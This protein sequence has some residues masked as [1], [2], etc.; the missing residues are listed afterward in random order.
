MA[1]NNVLLKNVFVKDFDEFMEMLILDKPIKKGNNITKRGEGK[2]ENKEKNREIASIRAASVIRALIIMNKLCYFWTLTYE[3]EN[4]DAQ[5]TDK[6]FNLFI[7]R[8]KYHLKI[9]DLKYVGVKEIQEKRAE[10]YGVKVWHIHFCTDK[11]LKFDDVWEI[12]GHGY[13]G[14]KKCDESELFKEASY[15]AK[16]IK[17]DIK[18]YH[19]EEKKRYYCSKG[20]KRPS[21]FS[22]YM[23]DEEKELLEESAKVKCR[24]DDAI[25]L[26]LTN[27]EFSE[28]SRRL[29]DMEKVNR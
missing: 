4:E 16:Y 19:T 25:W 6:D 9:D 28:Y 5:K 21:K 20:L 2:E 18:K 24:Y 22:V 23:T 15:V 1:K 17:K 8:L 26:R 14:V 13:V 29:N 27:E 10:K 12:W 3:S 7:K 11:Y